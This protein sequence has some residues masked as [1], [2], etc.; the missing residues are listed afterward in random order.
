MKSEE[1]IYYYEYD[2]L[3]VIAK[4]G[5]FF[6]INPLYFYNHEECGWEKFEPGDENWGYFY[7]KIGRETNDFTEEQLEK[8]KIPLITEE[9]VFL[10]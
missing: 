1:K 9:T 3:I 8:A 5:D 2:N 6:S 7:L 4:K 10:V